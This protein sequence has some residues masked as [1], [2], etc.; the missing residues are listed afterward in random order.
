MGPFLNE[1]NDEDQDQ[2]LAQNRSGKGLKEFVGDPERQ[3]PDKRAP[4]VADPPPNTTT[5]KLSMI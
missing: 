4:K 2:D 3:G 1:E 5:M